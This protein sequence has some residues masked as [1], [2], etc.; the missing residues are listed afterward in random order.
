MGNGPWARSGARS[1]PVAPSAPVAGYQIVVGIVRLGAPR[2]VSSADV[3]RVVSTNVTWWIPMA[4]TTP[5]PVG[6][7]GSGGGGGGGRQPASNAAD[8]A[9]LA[10][11]AIRLIARRRRGY[12]ELVPAADA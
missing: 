9:R 3:D 5:I 6:D 4:W 11:T 7:T 1:V 10:A 8:A 2:K 12:R